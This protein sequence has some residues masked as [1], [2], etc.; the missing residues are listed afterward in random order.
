[1][2]GTCVNI[3]AAIASG[4]FAGLISA[5]AYRKIYKKI[6]EKSLFD[7]YG[8]LNTLFISFFGTFVIA[9]IILIAYYNR[10]WILTTL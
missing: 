2:A 4:L 5:V 10:T 8:A 6:N 9:P 1:V 3:G 7:S